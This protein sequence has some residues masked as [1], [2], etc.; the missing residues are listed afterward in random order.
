MPRIV[1]AALLVCWIGSVSL[2]EWAVWDWH[3]AREE[4]PLGSAWH[5]IRAAVTAALGLAFVTSCAAVR[6]RSGHALGTGAIAAAAMVLGLALAITVL[7]AL[8]PRAYHAIVEEDG[9]VEWGSAL[10]LFLATV[11]AGRWFFTIYRNPPRPALDLVA[12]GGFALL[13][14]VMAMEEISWFQRVIGFDTPERIAAGNWQGEFNLHN[15]QTDLTELA[16]YSGTGLFLM[17]LPLL[18]E[19]LGNVR[20]FDRLVHLFPGRAVAAISAPMLM[21]TYGQFNLLPVQAATWIGAGVMAVFARDARAGGRRGEALLYHA[22]AASIVIGQ[23]AYLA[24]GP[25]MVEIFDATEY[26]EA[27]IALGLAAYASEMSRR[28]RS[29]ARLAEH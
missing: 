8:D 6:P 23:G 19:S 15:F 12:A 3:P 20:V 17:L 24:L 28:A 13:F 25:G 7:L 27:I 4:P 22:L 2:F 11:F 9:P 26:R 14:F 29:S 1:T 21:L 10:L 16:L 18:R 5:V